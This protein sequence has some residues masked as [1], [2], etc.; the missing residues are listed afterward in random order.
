MDEPVW[1]TIDR[2]LAVPP[3]KVVKTGY[4]RVDKVRLACRE[5]MAIG[6]VYLAYQ[7]RLQ[8]GDHQPWPCPRGYWNS[9][10]FVIVDGRHE[11]VANL[12][13]GH[14]YILVAWIEEDV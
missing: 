6:D 4:V 5:R 12:L 8:L 1:M 9:D 10:Q 11:F 7:K 13:I 14:D 3:G 2:S